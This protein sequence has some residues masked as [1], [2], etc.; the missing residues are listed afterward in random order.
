MDSYGSVESP[1]A[2]PT[3]RKL[4][5]ANLAAPITLSDIRQGAQWPPDRCRSRMDRMNRQWEISMGDYS[6][7]IPRAEER[8]REINRIGAVFD[9]MSDLLLT[10]EPG[11]DLN[12]EKL[13]MELRVAL[14]ILVYD[15]MRHGRGVVLG[16]DNNIQ[17]LS[18]RNTFPL[19]YNASMGW[20]TVRPRVTT[21]SQDGN[22][23]EVEFLIWL[24]ETNEYKGMVWEINGNS[25][26]RC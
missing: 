14:E 18:I 15:I 1:I 4:P 11:A 16:Y 8:T 25:L 24:R 2:I 23:N 12:D 21:K 6:Y 26:G 19:E 7:F 5:Q 17:A 13:Q 20:V 10:N 22:P 3:V 9:S